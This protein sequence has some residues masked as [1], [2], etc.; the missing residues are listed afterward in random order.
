MQPVNVKTR[1][2][3]PE[4]QAAHR[5]HQRAYASLIMASDNW[6]FALQ[7]ALDPESTTYDEDMAF[8]I[9][10]MKSE[11]KK[12]ERAVQTVG[13]LRSLSQGIGTAQ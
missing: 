11:V 5:E 12:L 3:T 10:D 9:C 2:Q 4:E 1:Y 8:V 7:R 13:N 6:I